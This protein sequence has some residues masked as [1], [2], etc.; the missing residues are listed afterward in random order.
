MVFNVG[1]SSSLK[2]D[3]PR[4]KG[5]KLWTGLHPVWSSSDFGRPS[6]STNQLSSQHRLD[7]IPEKPGR[8]PPRSPQPPSDLL[9]CCVEFAGRADGVQATVL[10]ERQEAAV[11]G[12]LFV[13][14][15]TIVLG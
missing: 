11:G 10:L 15:P 12:S 7:A 4:L 14:S 5:L 6:T 3:V 2:G 13:A 9:V 8:I 1:V